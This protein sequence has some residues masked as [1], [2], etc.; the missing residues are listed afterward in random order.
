ML[1]SVHCRISSTS[2]PLT[3]C[4]QKHI[5]WWHEWCGQGEKSLGWPEFVDPNLLPCHSLLVDYR[6][7]STVCGTASPRWI[8]HSCSRTTLTSAFWP[9]QRA[10]ENLTFSIKSVSNL[11][12]LCFLER[13]LASTSL[14]NISHFKDHW[15]TECTTMG[16][17]EKVERPARK[18]LL[19]S[20]I[21]KNI[22][23]WTTGITVE[24]W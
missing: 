19:E 2:P 17:G 14:E 11:S 4:F 21:G 1:D 8:G 20:K 12:C 23:T 22:R 6:D 7:L 13:I 9:C 15:A 16:R 5:S 24:V 18:L 3:L 10:W